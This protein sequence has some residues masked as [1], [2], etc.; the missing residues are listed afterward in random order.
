MLFQ[1][2]YKILIILCIFSAEP[3]T[4][5]GGFASRLVCNT[6]CPCS[7]LYK[8]HCSPFNVILE[9]QNVVVIIWDRNIKSDIPLVLQW[10]TV[11]MHI[12]ITKWQTLVMRKYAS[13]QTVL[14]KFSQE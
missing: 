10:Y 4:N 13:I 9:K 1:D 11:T 8:V 2:I 12:C 14:Q 7:T 6:D 5:D 3:V